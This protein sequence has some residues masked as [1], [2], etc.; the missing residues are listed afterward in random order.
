L[1]ETS[2]C[3]RARMASPELRGIELP[4]PRF[5]MGKLSPDLLH[6]NGYEHLQTFFPTL[7]KIFRIAKRTYDNEIWMDTKWRITS[8]DCSGTSGPCNVKLEENLDT[9]GSLVTDIKSV[10]MKVTH[11]LDPIHWIQGKYGLPK[12]MGLPWHHRSWM[13][14]C[15][16]LQDPGNQAYIE[17]IC[18][19]IVGRF[20]EEDI[21]PH[22]N[23]FYG[24]FCALAKRYMYNLTD[25][26][27]S[28]RCE[29]WFWNAYKR[30]IFK[31]KIEY[32]DNTGEP[33]TQEEIDEL[34]CEYSNNSSELSVDDIAWN[35]NVEETILE[36]VTLDD[37]TNDT[38]VLQK[39]KNETELSNDTTAETDVESNDM[40]YKIYAEISNY[41]VMLILTEKNTGT[42]DELFE[43]IKEAG[44]EPGTD[45]W[46]N[47]WTAWIFQVISALSCLQTLIGFTHNDL[48]TNNIVWIKTE[49]TYL[50]YKTNDN[51]YFKVPTYGKIFRIIDFGRSIFY[52]NR[53]MFISDDFKVGNDAEGQY[54]F[55]PI[56]QT[57]DKEI[58]PN[59][60]FDLCRLAV[61]MIDG[62]FRV[63]PIKR[64]RG[65]ILSKEP[66]LEIYETI[67]PLYNFLWCMMID[68]K[69]KNVFIK[70]NGTERFPGFDLYK[71]IAEFVHVA[72]PSQQIVHAIFEKYQIKNAPPSNQKVYLLF[73]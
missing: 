16:K 17:T 49:L 42:M 8:I 56:L 20:R 68:D 15:Q 29:R 13:S 31:C 37:F 69:G 1:A 46:E 34:I 61:S 54:A 41:P 25:D 19:Y 47:R 66:G 67:S 4:K 43:N 52:V 2:I 59:F 3:V 53:H 55:R 65:R 62:I 23:L 48:H 10:F 21:T 64:K 73:C 24:S 44:A 33:V 45:A 60:S 39:T 18:S 51:T 5:R 12:N 40:P 58:R 72:I 71:H 70:P 35:E 14:T 63:K 22:F 7:T 50:Y 57:F 28:Y 36:E 27:N 26:Y 38:I 11:L 9:S 30:G 32:A 6:V